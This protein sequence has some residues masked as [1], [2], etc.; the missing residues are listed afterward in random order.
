MFAINYAATLKDIAPAAL[1]GLDVTG[2]SHAG[3]DGFADR[4]VRCSISSLNNRP[5][6]SNVWQRLTTADG[7]VDTFARC[8]FP[9]Q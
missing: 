9:A 1:T 3:A 7:I 2:F 8:S 4:H 6:S 5:P